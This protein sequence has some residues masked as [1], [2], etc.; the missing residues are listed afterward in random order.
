MT[1]SREISSAQESQLRNEWLQRLQDLLKQTKQWAEEQEWSARQIEKTLQDSEIGK[2]TVPMLLLQQDAVRILLE[3]IARNAPGAEG[4]V[5]LYLM[6][7][8]DDI[9][10][11]YFVKGGWQLHYMFPEDKTVATIRDAKSTPLS[12]ESFQH[13]LSAMKEN[14]A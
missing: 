11:F 7:A 14:A 2:H 3:P 9:A 6:P 8:Y 13:V 1:A 5:D 10:S 4:V 12:Q